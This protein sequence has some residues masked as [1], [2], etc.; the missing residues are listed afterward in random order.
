[1]TITFINEPGASTSEV[2]G[3]CSAAA[4]AHGFVFVT[5]RAPQM[6]VKAGPDPIPTVIDEVKSSLE[7][8]ERILARAGCT[9]EDLVKVTCWV[10]NNADRS[11]I[12]TAL[13]HALGPGH[14]STVLTVAAGITDNARVE[15]DAIAIL[16]AGKPDGSVHQPELPSTC[17]AQRTSQSPPSTLSEPTT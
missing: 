14:R 6:G 1:M 4:V 17:R 5:G 16:P 3:G 9:L 11:D 13:H 7:R 2:D 15:I 8:I 12:L 10:S